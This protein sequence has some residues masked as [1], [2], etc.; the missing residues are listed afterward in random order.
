MAGYHLYNIPRGE[1]GQF[2]KISEEFLEFT[3]AL[4]QNCHVMALVELSDLM[5]SIK[6]YYKAHNQ[7]NE[8]D[9]IV[10]SV[11]NQPQNK[12]VDFFDL[13][14]N[15]LI[16]NSASPE[17]KWSKFELFISE[18]H[19]YV[20]KYNLTLQDLMVMAQITERVFVNGYR[21]PR[22]D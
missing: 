15:F 2:S 11:Q 7:Q 4:D 9:S 12:P 19:Q 18:L 17:N 5:G 8:F 22:Q 13:E 10:S 14:E 6:C 21:T 3:D 1:L 16:L 20:K